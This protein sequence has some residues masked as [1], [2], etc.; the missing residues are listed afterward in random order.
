MDKMELEEENM[1]WR[2]WDYRRTKRTWDREHGM[3]K[4]K[5]LGWPVGGLDGTASGQA[6]GNVGGQA[7]GGGQT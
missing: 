6:L 1:G 5:G 4:E 2:R 7:G 3:E